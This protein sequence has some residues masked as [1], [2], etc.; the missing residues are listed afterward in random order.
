[1]KRLFVTFAAT[2][3]YALF[4]SVNTWGQTLLLEENFNYPAGDSLTAH[5]WTAHSGS[6]TNPITANNGGLTYAGYANSGINNAA[7]V[8]NNG[9]DD[10]RTFTSQTS[11]T[12]YYSFLVKV[13][14]VA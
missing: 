1:M 6:T 13:D 3:T 12:I 4:V 2:L 5:G 9:E 7:L 14:S 10:N 8:D 11:G